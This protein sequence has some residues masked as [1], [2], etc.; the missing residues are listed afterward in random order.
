[1]LDI[2]SKNVVVDGRAVQVLGKI[3]C[4][5][6]AGS[7]VSVIGPS[8]CGKSTLLRAIM[9]LDTDFAGQI[10]IGDQ[11]VQ[12]PGV[13]RGIVFQEPR[14]LPWAS[15][16]ENIAFAIPTGAQSIYTAGQVE[17]LMDLFGLRDFANAW[18]NQLSGG[19]MQRVAL[20]RALVNLPEVLLM[21]EPFGALDAHTKTLMQEE[22]LGI[23]QSQLTTTA[24]VT[25]DVEEA[26]YLSDA[27]LVLSGRPGSLVEL[28][29]V[30]LSKPRDRSDPAFLAL[31]FDVLRRA[32]GGEPRLPAATQREPRTPEDASKHL[33]ILKRT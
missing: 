22:L 20:A 17:R 30:G 24:M 6:E 26:V 14:L 3:S 10:H 31:R 4:L 11:L 25:H 16:R 33:R 2:R 9:G 1:M 29:Q 15:V 12:R 7:F 13:D 23:F 21:D 8:G 18:P 32:F 19:M 28:V 27:V 5:I